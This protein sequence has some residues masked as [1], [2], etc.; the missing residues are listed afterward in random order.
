MIDRLLQRGVHHLILLCTVCGLSCAEPVGNGP[1]FI[2]SPRPGSV[3][4][5]LRIPLTAWLPSEWQ[6]AQIRVTLDGVD[7]SDPVG[8]VRGRGPKTGGPLDY[9][10][11]LDLEGV[12]DGAHNLWVI[13]Q[14]PNGSEEVVV[15]RFNVQAHP[16]RVDFRIVDEDGELRP[17]RVL[18]FDAQNQPVNIRGPDRQAT[19]PLFREAIGYAAFASGG[20]GSF[21]V[22]Q[23]WYRF[24]A[25]AGIRDAVSSKEMWVHNDTALTFDVP[26]VV[27]TPGSLA[28][29]CMCTQDTVGMRSSPIGSGFRAWSQPTW[30]WWPSPTTIESGRPDQPSNC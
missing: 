14:F 21:R 3:V 5:D 20:E 11:M 4:G 25:A 10:A 28:A 17:G 22:P 13:A 23:G 27:E 6:D 1:P 18:V 16:M 19:D 7:I 9:M 15:S 26:R 30:M 2:I 8:F 12:A 24:I 29:V